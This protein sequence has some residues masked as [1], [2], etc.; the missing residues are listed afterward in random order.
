MTPKTFH[1]ALMPHSLLKLL[2]LTQ[3]YHCET[4]GA[5]F[6]Y[7]G[8]AIYVRYFVPLQLKNH[9]LVIHLHE[10]YCTFAVGKSYLSHPFMLD[11][12][13]LCGGK[14]YLSSSIYSE[15]NCAFV[16]GK[17]YLG[18]SIYSEINCTFAV[19]KSYLCHP[20]T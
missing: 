1:F 9:C 7:H 16:V 20:F 3:Q 5:C 10:I 2:K 17:S 15:I 11:I 13:Y 6:S 4:H 12:L 18:S 8:L 19:G 14:S